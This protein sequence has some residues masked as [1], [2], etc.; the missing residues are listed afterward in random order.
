MLFSRI[1]SN[2]YVRNP[3]KMGVVIMEIITFLLS[4]YFTDSV[5]RRQ[6]CEQCH[7]VCQMCYQSLS[8]RSSGLKI[9]PSIKMIYTVLSQNYIWPDHGQNVTLFDLMGGWL[10]GCHFSWYWKS[11]PLHPLELLVQSR[12]KIMIILW[13]GSLQ[14]V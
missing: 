3:H 12:K 11:T 1:F 4:K 7:L 14:F 2:Y 13:N 9:K 6:N 8:R 10:G 5:R